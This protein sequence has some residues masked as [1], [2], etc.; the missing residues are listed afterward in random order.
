MHDGV[1]LAEELSI[2]Q[3]HIVALMASPG[4]PQDKLAKSILSSEYSITASYVLHLSLCLYVQEGMKGTQ[5]ASPHVS[6]GTP[7]G[8]KAEML[9]T[10]LFS[11]LG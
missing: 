1:R 5:I 9:N 2:F 4:I 8:A 11:C 3:L 10:S 7:S 6:I